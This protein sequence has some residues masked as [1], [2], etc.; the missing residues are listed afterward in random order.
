MSSSA[1]H[2]T[3]CEW[4]AGCLPLSR[5]P[6]FVCQYSPCGAKLGLVDLVG[7]KVL[8]TRDWSEEM[9]VRRANVQLLSFSPGGQYLVS[10][11]K[12]ADDAPNLLVW[13]TRAA[14]ALYAFH[15]KQFLKDLWPTVVFTAHDDCLFT[16]HAG[17]VAMFRLPQ[18]QPGAVLGD[19]RVSG[20]WLA[21]ARPLVLA[22]ASEQKADTSKIS[23][24]E[25]QPESLNKI[26]ELGIKFVQEVKVLWNK[27]S[28]RA[29]IWCQTDVDSTGRSYYGEHSLY[30]YTP[31]PKLKPVKTTE[32]PIHDVQWNPQSN[33]PPATSTT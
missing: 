10:W 17:D 4:C 27:D 2:G 16:R 29:V 9:S 24:F 8:L 26:I 14:S 21:P 31:D 32:G 30:I 12:P 19:P 6:C 7:I 13:D 5:S 18:Q 20:F 11:E 1:E 33:Q 22:C 28:D 15:Q 25:K 3:Q 23:V